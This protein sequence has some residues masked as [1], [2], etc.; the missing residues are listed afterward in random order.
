V[1][2]LNGVLETALYV[3]DLERS[4][5]FY[6]DIFQLE[7]IA[8]DDRFCALNVAGRQVL[9]LFL[10][11]GTAAPVATPSGAIPSHDGDGHLHFA[12]S[13]PASR[14]QAWEDW[15]HE[16]RVTGRRQGPLA[17]GR[18]EPLSQGSD[19]HL[20]ELATRG[21]GPSTSSVPTSARDARDGQRAHRASRRELTLFSQHSIIMAQTYR[22]WPYSSVLPIG[23]QGQP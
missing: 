19:G 13:T 6:R 1:P 23:K 4:I 14:L 11:G 17:G 5:Q 9:L 18:N 20:A 16:K 10:K 7:V 12:F 22:V 3:G 21:C 15:L 8:G 2:I